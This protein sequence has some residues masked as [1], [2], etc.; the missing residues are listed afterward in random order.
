MAK[1]L[2]HFVDETVA[3]AIANSTTHGLGVLLSITALIILTVY[4]SMQNDV[5]KIVSSVLYGS[6]LIAMY[7][8][9]TFYHLLRNPR[10][11]H[12]LRILDHSTIYL[13]IAGTYTPITLVSLQGVWG[14][15]LFGLVWSIALF[16]IVFK[17]FFVHR[18]EIVSTLLYLFMGWL[19]II[20]IEPIIKAL[21]FTA[22]AWIIA[23]G[24]FYSVGVIFYLWK[25]LPFGHTIWH[26]FVLAGSICHFFAILFYVVMPLST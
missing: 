10:V 6:T 16:G 21:P 17:F 15:T 12:Y 7:S 20:A 18:F 4:S 9:S 13:L 26:L 23:G 11:R 22:L 24:L 1:N 2:M 5:V 14:W 8:A 25:K 3:E 19:A